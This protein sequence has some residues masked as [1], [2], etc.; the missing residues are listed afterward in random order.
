[1]SSQNSSFSNESGRDTSRSNP[2]PSYQNEQ[3]AY[4]DNNNKEKESQKKDN[5]LFKVEINIGDGIIKELNIYKLNELDKSIDDFCMENNLPEE[6]KVPIKDLLL[7]N[8]NEKI[9]KC[10]LYLI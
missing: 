4:M 5:Y 1:M 10:K 2:S 9:S 8:I 6:S 3:V 7:K